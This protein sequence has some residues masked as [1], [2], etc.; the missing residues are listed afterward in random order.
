MAKRFTDSEKWKRPWF[1]ELPR[2]AKFVWGYLL[3]D[4]D[5]RGVWLANFRRLEF[6]TG[7]EVDHT[8]LK[9]W[10][11]TK[12][13][14]IDDDKYFIPSFVVFQYGKL[15]PSNNAHKPILKL[16]EERPE[17]NVSGEIKLSPSEA[18]GQ[19]LPGPC[20]GALDKDKDKDKCIKKGGVGENEQPP[21]DPSTDRTELLESIFKLYPKRKGDQGKARGFDRLRKFS[22]GQ[23]EQFKKAVVAY[24]RHC[25]DA[26]KVDSEYVKQFA[27]FTNKIWEEWLP[28]VNPNLASL[29]PRKTDAE[30]IAETEERRRIFLAEQ[31]RAS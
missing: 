18:P 9:E 13:V 6:D 5:S 16:L 22:L 23:L 2:D 30:L 12:L 4:C 1:A 24:A 25:V 20:Q 14:S 11:G 31:G 7:I 27:T 15:K 19:P 8:D 29:P 21:A 28:E 3:D 10:F 17:L 26:R